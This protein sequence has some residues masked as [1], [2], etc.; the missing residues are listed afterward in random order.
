MK[1][2]IYEFGNV[3]ESGDEFRAATDLTIESFKNLLEFLNPGEDS[4]NVTFYDSSSRLSESCDD[5]E[6]P[7]YGPKAKLLSR[8]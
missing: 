7:N 3:S 1:S 8:D 2:H 5:I 4:C 6:S